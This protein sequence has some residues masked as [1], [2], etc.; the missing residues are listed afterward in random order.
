MSTPSV[1]S[2]ED[3]SR[4]HRRS[5]APKGV[6]QLGLQLPV[7]EADVK[8]AYFKQAQAAHP[9]HGGK[10]EDFLKV[11]HAFEEALEFAK[12]NG[13]RLP[14]IGAQ[15]ELYVAQREAIERVE[16]WGGSVGVESLD[17]LQETVGGDFTQLAD[18][19]KSIDLSGRPVADAQLVEL[20][21][22]PKLLPYLETVSLASTG[23]TDAG[24]TAPRRWN[25]CR[26]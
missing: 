22:E 25:G 4:S 20:L 13:K 24:A 8:Q 5:H 17:W 18:R 2:P 11:Q 10:A 12:R 14:W 6:E 7:T 3:S 21:G 15:M 23:V 9:D 16:E 26:A 1:P 19:L